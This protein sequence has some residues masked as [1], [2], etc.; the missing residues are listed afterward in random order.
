MQVRQALHRGLTLA[1]TQKAVDL[2]P[3]RLRFT[4][5]DSELNA[6]FEGNFTPIVRQMYDEA[7]EGLELYQ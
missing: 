3:I 2:T 4:H 6:S 1:E 7:T 5:D